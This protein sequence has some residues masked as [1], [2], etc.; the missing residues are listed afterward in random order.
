MALF[1]G[2]GSNNNHAK[3]GGRDEEDKII[4]V[5]KE[6]EAGTPIVELCRRHGISDAKK[7]KQKD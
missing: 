2:R 4:G 3:Q 1:F 7:L 5:L 6:E